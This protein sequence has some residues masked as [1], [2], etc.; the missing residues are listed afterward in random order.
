MTTTPLHD[1]LNEWITV[2]STAN[3]RYDKKKVSKL[4]KKANRGDINT[5][6]CYQACLAAGIMAKPEIYIVPGKSRE[7]SQHGL[8]LSE[9]RELLL[10]LFSDAV[11]PRYFTMKNKAC[12]RTVVVVHVMDATPDCLKGL[13]SSRP[14]LVRVSRQD[15]EWNLLPERLLTMDDEE[16]QLLIDKMQKHGGQV[17]TDVNV[18]SV[19]GT[20]QEEKP[21]VESEKTENL[22]ETNKNNS[23]S[24]NPLMD[25]LLTKLAPYVMTEGALRLWGYPLPLPSSTTATSISTARISSSITASSIIP[26]MCT[27]DQTTSSSSS[28]S[29]SSTAAAETSSAVERPLKR[30]RI[31]N[32]TVAD[33]SPTP[34]NHNNNNHNNGS[35]HDNDDDDDS[36][37]ILGVLTGTSQHLMPS[38]RFA[39]RLLG[40]GVGSGSGLGSDGDAHV[41]TA[42]SSSAAAAASSSSLTSS[43]SSLLSP[44]PTSTLRHVQVMDGTTLLD[45]FVETLPT[46]SIAYQQLWP[47]TTT[48]T[49]TTA[50]VIDEDGGEGAGGGGK[51]SGGGGEISTEGNDRDPCVRSPHP[52]VAVDCEMCDT[53][54]GLVLT[55]LTLVDHASQVINTVTI[56]L[57]SIKQHHLII[58]PSHNNTLPQ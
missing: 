37:M 51:D 50:M 38:N 28:S 36:L 5:L 43:S 14:V 44:L 18:D 20:K 3:D 46:H 48:T 22:P 40:L 6:Q 23:S 2:G 1:D 57:Y 56:T 8:N 16:A 24:G 58:T 31:D 17:S 30:P 54:E 39:Q 10:S 13:T 27:E 11:P 34:N 41:I 35:S 9:I 21:E 15:R 47:I 29:S 53:S 25:G 12:I 49:M 45:N 4:V 7:N 42:A 26:A 52:L 55:R 33:Q 19:V 32:S